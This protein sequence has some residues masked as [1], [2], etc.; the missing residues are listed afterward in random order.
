[1][2]GKKHIET[3][4]KGIKFILI[5]L[6]ID[7][8][9]GYITK[10]FFYSQETGKY[11]RST[12]A[13]KE[14]EAEILILGSS[15]AHRHY[16][17]EVIEKELGKSCYNAGA[18][19]QQ[20]VYHLALL[21]MILKR[22][23]PKTIILNIDEDFLLE[24]E[25]AYS[26]LS[27][28]HPYYDEYSKE[29]KPVLGLRSNFVDVKLFFHLYQMNSTIMHI[30]RYG[31]SPQVDYKG[32]RPLFGTI[33]KSNDQ[34][35]KEDNNRE[36]RGDVIDQNFVN[37]LKNIIITVKKKNINLVFVTSPSYNEV[38][39]SKNISFSKIKEIIR[40][41]NVSF[42]DFI[43]NPD[44]IHKN[45]LFHDPSHLND[46]GSKLFSKQVAQRIRRI[47]SGE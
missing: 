33:K 34:R 7:F 42:I 43:N 15:H 2:I 1:M 37:T 31:A 12:Q 11:A 36:N 8:S 21:D 44:F 5:L 26:R 16:V 25:E 6:V 9:L 40:A 19:G 47:H 22:Y 10:Q 20:L 14:T 3:L 27:D 39:H 32:Y 13:I 45:E 4:R 38:D 28:L 29:L 46:S 18:E 35:H 23:T 30:I 17:P 41:E 24:F